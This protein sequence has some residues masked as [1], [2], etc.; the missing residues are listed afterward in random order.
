MADTRESNPC[1]SNGLSSTLTLA[2]D[3]YAFTVPLGVL[4]H[5]F[6]SAQKSKV[7]TFEIVGLP[8]GRI[9][10]EVVAKHTIF[11]HAIVTIILSVE[12]PVCIDVETQ[13]T[14]AQS[15]ITHTLAYL[16]TAPV[17]TD[18]CRTTEDDDGQ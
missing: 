11:Q 18:T 7:H 8:I 13:C 1:C 17:S 6:D 5:V 14:I 15:R 2:N 4:C 9:V 12:H 3:E 10:F 16:T